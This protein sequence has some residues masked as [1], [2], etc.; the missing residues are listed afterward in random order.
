MFDSFGCADA[1]SMMPSA[2]LKMEM[3][4]S[5]FV[6]KFYL[7]FLWLPFFYFFF[8]L[9]FCGAAMNGKWRKFFDFVLG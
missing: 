8:P 9:R 5:P 6:S 3:E 2:I 7:V 4:F 1:S